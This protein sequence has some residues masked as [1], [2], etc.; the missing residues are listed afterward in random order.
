MSKARIEPDAAFSGPDT[1]SVPCNTYVDS[2]CLV[3]IGFAEHLRAR[4]V[5]DALTT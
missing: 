5:V 1:Y 3:M 4:D 2:L